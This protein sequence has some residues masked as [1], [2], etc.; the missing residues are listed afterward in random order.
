MDLLWELLH[1]ASSLS[2]SFHRP[3]QELHLQ[4]KGLSRF[5]LISLLARFFESRTS[6]KLCHI[7]LVQEQYI[8]RARLTVSSMKS[9][10]VTCP[11][12]TLQ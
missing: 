4:G 8:I 3:H 6:A 11:P 10:Y 12:S 9:I 5:D 7:E 2:F 1:L